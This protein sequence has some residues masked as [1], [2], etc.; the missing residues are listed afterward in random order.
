LIAAVLFMSVLTVATDITIDTDTISLGALIAFPP[1][2]SRASISLGYAPNPG[3]ARRITKS[4]ILNKLALAGK[5]SD[6]L[7]LPDSILVHRQT[8]GLNRDQVTRAILG[9]FISRFPGANIEIINV[10]IPTIQV[11]TG[12]IEISASLP[13]RFDPSAPVFVRV[14]VKGTSF[15]KTVFARTV[16][17]VEAEQPVLKN[18]I[19]AHS[20]IRPEDIER[21]MMPI[22]PTNAAE[23]VD[24]LLAKRN[25]EPGQVIT[26]DLL[27]V[28]LYVHKGDSVTVKATSGAVTIA[29][30][31]RA[32][33]A[34]KL[35]ETI[36][37]EH[38]SG[39]GSTMARVV[40]PRL[41][42]VSK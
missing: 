17:R 24:G 3:L 41:L 12:A 25:L 7:L 15:A 32:K 1:G 36:P 28:P 37:V 40:G 35:G 11:G 29:A 30:T 20:E 2:D 31:M 8:A 6:D 5:P 39:E 42:E 19:E 9:A 38:L 10:D 27:Y 21:K 26:G 16:V 23:Q 13:A 18:K 4:E 14:D 22:R 34:G 33:A